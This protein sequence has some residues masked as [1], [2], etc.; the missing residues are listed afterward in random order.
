MQR[1]TC[2]GSPCVGDPRSPYSLTF[3]AIYARAKYAVPGVDLAG[4][5]A[6]VPVEAHL[7]VVEYAQC[8]RGA[9]AQREYILRGLA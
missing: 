8:W 7:S 9:Y 2:K 6:A 3:H 1:G 5:I 4:D